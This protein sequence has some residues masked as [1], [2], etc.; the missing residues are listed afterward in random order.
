MTHP[1]RAAKPGDPEAIRR[2]KAAE[3]VAN[4]RR[5]QDQGQAVLRVTIDRVQLE[6]VLE[7]LGGLPAGR[8]H[9]R[10]AVEAALTAHLADW[11]A[12][13]M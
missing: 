8:E 1:M 6:H 7:I 11:L 3:R 10:R 9:P 4:C 2:A 12:A 13:W 5:R